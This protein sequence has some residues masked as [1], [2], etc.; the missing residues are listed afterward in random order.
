M[1]MAKTKRATRA[2]PTTARPTMAGLQEQIDA[3]N[4]RVGSSVKSLIDLNS[5]LQNRFDNL[6]KHIDGQSKHAASQSGD[7]TERVTQLAGRVNRFEGVIDDY[8]TRLAQSAEFQAGINKSLRE[9]SDTVLAMAN[10]I[11]DKVKQLETQLAQSIA[12]QSKINADLQADSDAVENK[13]DLLT[14][15]VEKFGGENGQIAMA[16]AEIKSANK[17]SLWSWAPVGIIALAISI[18][19]GVQRGC[20]HGS[21]T[22]AP[23]ENEQSIIEPTKAKKLV[24]TVIFIHDRDPMSPAD[25]ALLQACEDLAD[26]REDFEFKSYDSVDDKSAKVANYKSKAKDKGIDPPFMLNIVGDK[27]SYAPMAKD[28]AGVVKV[29]GK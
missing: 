7:A 26:S 29:F 5:G 2:E 20:N 27:A 10:G 28:F 15:T 8:S 16:L 24:G 23:D 13:L 1:K 6:A 17:P 21:P 18:F 12:T 25:V 11:L 14:K 3:M 4:T 22:P 9:D 19:L